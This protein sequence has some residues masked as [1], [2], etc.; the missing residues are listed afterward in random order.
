MKRSFIGGARFRAHI[1]RRRWMAWSYRAGVLLIALAAAPLLAEPPPSSP[2]TEPSTQPS[3]LQIII[4]KTEEYYAKI[5][6]EPLNAADRL[7][8]EIAIISLSRIDAPSTTQK[9]LDVFKSKD[10]DPVVWYLAW[11]AL[12]PRYASMT[13]Q[14]RRQW[15]T[16]GLHAAA[17]GGFPGT[18][19]TPLLRALAE[20]EPVE[21]ESD[22]YKLAARVIQENSLDSTDQTATLTAL[23]DLIAAWHDPSLIKAVSALLA[24]PDLARRVDYV[25]RKLP[26][27]P[28]ESR[29]PRQI[30]SQWTAWIAESKIKVATASELSPYQGTA[31]VFP[32]PS[33][34]TD[35]ED[36]RWRAELEIGKLTVSDFDLVWCV[37]STG[38]MNET[39][40]RVAAETGLVVRVCSLVSRQ[41]RC[42]TVYARHEIDPKFMEKCCKEAT[43]GQKYQIKE[44]ALTTDVK[45]LAA[46]MAVERIPKPDAKVEGNMH[47]G[48]P[49]LGAMQVAVDRMNWSKD[50]NARKIVVLVG[51]AKPTPGT[52]STAEKF[53]ESMHSRGFS[54]YAL[55]T[56]VATELWPP[57]IKAGGGEVVPMGGG[58]GGGH[59]NKKQPRVQGDGPSALTPF[60]EVAA[61][62][63]RD[64]VASTYRDR[65]DPLVDIWIKY[66]VAMEQAEQTAAGKP[67]R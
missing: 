11:E 15:A 25:L 34:I 54:L 9:L 56:R 47:P 45:A 27:A 29:D 52:E 39:N 3:K 2:A 61:A 12:H 24:K 58:G 30:Q 51:D 42:G 65:V 4:T 60:Q 33:R 53:A 17:A 8:R 1:A 49:V 48:T 66:A 59:K 64:A 36:P 23:R 41:A 28:A 6:G 14:E 31:D 43:G 32:A 10:R 67:E 62:A 16:G 44:Y 40:Q 26:G 63:I 55:T 57:I 7:P 18:T 46:K 22:P 50:K 38:S 19:A 37:D 13:K 20:H 5:Y 21:F 35:P